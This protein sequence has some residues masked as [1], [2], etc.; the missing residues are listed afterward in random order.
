MKRGLTRSYAAGLGTTG[1]K[2]R[3]PNVL[4]IVFNTLENDPKPALIGAVVATF[5]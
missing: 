4:L 3:W 5:F 2:D 1:V